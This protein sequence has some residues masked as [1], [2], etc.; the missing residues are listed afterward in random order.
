M[1]VIQFVQ[2]YDDL[3]TDR[4]YQFKFHCDKCGNGYLSSYQASFVG[5]AGGLLRA[6]GD[7]FGGMLSNAG[8]SAFEIQRAVG[9]QGHDA[10][11]TA[12]VQETKQRF[13]QCSRCGKWVCPEICWNSKANQCHECAPNLGE[14][15]AAAQAQ[16]RV[17]AARQ[18][19]QEKALKTDYTSGIDMSADSV[20]R[21]PGPDQSALPTPAGKFC[22]QCGVNVGQ[23]KFCPECG[24][25]VQVSKPRCA[26]C[27]FEPTGGT[28]F[29]PEC[30]NR[31]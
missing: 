11:L 2:N 30:G 5:T 22:Q 6:A 24:K 29:C 3:S 18:Q 28:K 21:S 7:L 20:L 15:L 13:R 9:G 12:A 14:E 1:S 19:L 23:A 8:N 4:G 16:A 17:E 31:M 26:K 27:G 10:A 25:P